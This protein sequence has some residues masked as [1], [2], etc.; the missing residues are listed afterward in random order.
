MK[1]LE[2][3]VILDAEVQATQ[4]TAQHT[5]TRTTNTGSELQASPILRNGPD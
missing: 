4:H 1:D 5:K 2:V 3:Q